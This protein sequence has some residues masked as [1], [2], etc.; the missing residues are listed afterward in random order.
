[1]ILVNASIRILRQDDR[2]ARN[3]IANTR[4]CQLLIEA[5]YVKPLAY[6]PSSVLEHSVEFL[7]D[8]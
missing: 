3:D 8:I 5:K 7:S 1:M 4:I 6:I 2:P